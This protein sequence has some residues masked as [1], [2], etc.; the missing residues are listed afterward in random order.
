VG[1][2]SYPAREYV[3]VLELKGRARVEGLIRGQGEHTCDSPVTLEESLYT[4]IEDLVPDR[5]FT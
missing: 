5:S 3:S 1:N 4:A 2:T